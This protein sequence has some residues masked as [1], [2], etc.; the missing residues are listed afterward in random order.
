MAEATQI[1]CLATD[2]GCTFFSVRLPVMN[3]LLEEG[4]HEV[5]F[6][7]VTDIRV[8]VIPKSKNKEG[9]SESERECERASERA[10]E[11]ERERERES[12][13]AREGERACRVATRC[14]CTWAPVEM[15][16]ASV[17]MEEG[18]RE[19]ARER[20]RER[21]REITTCGQAQ[22]PELPVLERVLTL[23]QVW[24]RPRV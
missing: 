16:E 18:E 22:I 11:R 24:A 5:L 12:A 14:C 8:Q 21:E 2:I 13:R 9:G 20:E 15:E 6:I 23:W 1:G 7:S 4:Q 17:R 10:S 3:I 19:S